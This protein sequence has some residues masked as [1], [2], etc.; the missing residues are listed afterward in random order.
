[1][2]DKHCKNSCKLVLEDT[3]LK[4]ALYVDAN[5]DHTYRQSPSW[6]E[7]FTKWGLNQDPSDSQCNGLNH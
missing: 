4:H 5:T 7:P 2:W 6:E 1:M 3:I